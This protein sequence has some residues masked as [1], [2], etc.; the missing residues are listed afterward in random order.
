MVQWSDR[1]TRKNP[2]VAIVGEE[3]VGMAEIEADGFIDYFYVHPKWQGRGIGK[4]LLAVLE[5]EMAKLG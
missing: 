1:L 3:V 5:A 2:F 4:A